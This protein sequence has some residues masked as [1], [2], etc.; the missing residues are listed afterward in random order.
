MGRISISIDVE[1]DLHQ[2]TDKGVLEGIPKLVKII[3][4][5]RVKGTFFI[6]CDVL[7]KNERLFQEL[8]KEGHEIELH[9]FRHERFDEKLK[10]EKEE[11]IEKSI[12]CFK[13][14][15]GERPKGF[16]AV[17]HSIEPE[18]LEV[19]KKYNFR[20]DSSI[21]PWN[22]HHI[23]WPQIKIRWKNNF[24]SMKVHKW[25]GVWEVPI[26][27]FKLPLSALTIRFLPFWMF[28]IW[29]RFMNLKK[30]K[31]FFMHSWDMIEMPK[32]KLYRNCGLG[33][34]LK[35][36]EYMLGWFKKSNKFV[37]IGDLI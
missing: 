6:T 18:G 7:E 30:D 11:E 15:F 24:K 22:I 14:I 16:R 33:E 8:K 9:G 26:S 1:P 31:V 19:L 29:L 34:F 37:R 23:L 5:Y 32:S 35:R 17:Q 2:G 36:F 27:S 28:K 21:V 12:D 25:G 20:Y 4:K 10:K 3:D 13:K